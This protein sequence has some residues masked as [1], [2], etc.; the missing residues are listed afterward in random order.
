MDMGKLVEISE[1]MFHLI[2]Y[3]G[4]YAKIK[5]RSELIFFHKIQL[6]VLYLQ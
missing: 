4:L 3:I 5:V 2:V 6:I 1:I